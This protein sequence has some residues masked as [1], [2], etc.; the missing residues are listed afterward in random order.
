MMQSSHYT[1]ANVISTSSK[2]KHHMCVKVHK[3]YESIRSTRPNV[4]EKSNSH[5]Y[6]LKGGR[7]EVGRR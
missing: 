4:V 5:L 7:E 1:V 2:Q 6:F 3:H